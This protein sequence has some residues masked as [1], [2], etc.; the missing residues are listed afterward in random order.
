MKLN[1]NSW[2]VW[3]YRS[4]YDLTVYDLPNNLC[5][6][7]WK[8]VLAIIMLPLSWIGHLFNIGRVQT[9]ALVVGSAISVLIMIS[10]MVAACQD[11]VKHITLKIALKYY[12]IGSF[13][14]VLVAVALGIVILVLCGIGHICEYI[15]DKWQD[16]SYK[17]SKPSIIT[18]FIKAKY[19]KYCPKIE[20]TK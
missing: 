14:L 8:L 4:S 12:A 3:I 5:P 10:G 17:E 11:N 9:K 7:F 13:Y 19:N 18:T 1:L 20:W 15:K 16:R 6:F 2:Y